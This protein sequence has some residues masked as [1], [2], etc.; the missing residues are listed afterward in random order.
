M[1]IAKN[2]VGQHM[3][4]AVKIGVAGIVSI[5]VARVL[6]LPQ[7][8]WTAISAFVVMG[9]DVGATIVASRNRLIGTAIGAALAAVFV[10]L[11]GSNL[12]WFGIAVAATALICESVG[13]GQSYRMACVTVAIV[14]LINAADSPWRSAVYRFI[15]VALGIVIALLIS[16]LPP[17]SVNE[18]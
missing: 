15:E 10:A 5:L 1:E 8:Y 9:S 2:T 7:G 17:K 3:V 4:Q 14:M 13:L 18:L 6:K 16:A 12:M 11:L